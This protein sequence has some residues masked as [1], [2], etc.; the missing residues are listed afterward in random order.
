MLLPT[1]KKQQ[2]Y[3]KKTKTNHSN[4]TQKHLCC[5]DEDIAVFKISGDHVCISD[6]V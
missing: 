6:H 1:I 2:E 3:M 4:K 5:L